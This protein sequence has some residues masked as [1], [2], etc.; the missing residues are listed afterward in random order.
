VKLWGR[1]AIW[2]C[3]LD[4]RCSILH[5]QKCNLGRFLH[6]RKCKWST[7]HTPH[8][9]FLLSGKPAAVGSLHPFFTE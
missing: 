9:T 8:S 5:I 7:L 2:A 1:E 4:S 6:I 3:V